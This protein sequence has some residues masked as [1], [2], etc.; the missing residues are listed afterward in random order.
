MKAK[1][2][3]ILRNTG[4][5]DTTLARMLD[6][7]P[8]G[9]SHILSGRNKPS[10]DL[11]VKILKVFP[12]L[13]PD[14]LL[15]DSEKIFRQEAQSATSPAAVLR[16][17]LPDSPLLPFDAAKNIDTKKSENGEKNEL[18]PIFTSPRNSG[19]KVER[20]IILYSDRSFESYTEL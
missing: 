9:L 5:N 6:I 17:D 1:L 12:D 18:P 2:E 20:V 11:V 14:W 4:I 8:S 7:Q 13:N 16:D 10:F 19:K 15:L 3:F